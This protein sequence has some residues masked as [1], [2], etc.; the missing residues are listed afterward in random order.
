M[1][2]SEITESMEVKFYKEPPFLGETKF[3]ARNLVRMLNTAAM[4]TNAK[5]ISRTDG[6]IFTKLGSSI[7]DSSQ[8]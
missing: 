7:W 3:Y 1:V 4:L 6:P 2:V 5:K 8:S